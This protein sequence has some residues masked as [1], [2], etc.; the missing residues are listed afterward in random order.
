M[1]S[2]AP[3]EVNRGNR[4]CAEEEALISGYLLDLFLHLIVLLYS[5]MGP[6]E[7]LEDVRFVLDNVP[8]NMLKPF[9]VKSHKFITPHPVIRKFV[10]LLEVTETDPEFKLQP[11]QIEFQDSLDP[12]Y[13]STEEER[14]L[15]YREYLASAPGMEGIRALGFMPL[16]FSH[17]YIH[18][19]ALAPGI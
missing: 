13:P 10:P 16:E 15:I 1:I 2:Y 8:S 11:K 18:K 3:M 7:K 4:T 17:H 6:I 19:L 9:E 14:D 5:P 12:A